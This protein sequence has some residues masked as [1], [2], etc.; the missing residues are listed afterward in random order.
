MIAR[1]H[2]PFFRIAPAIEIP[3][4]GN[5]PGIRYRERWSNISHPD[6]IDWS[7]YDYDISASEARSRFN[8]L[9][10]RGE[11][12]YTLKFCNGAHDLS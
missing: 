2:A 11:E 4:D 6:V 12:F 9:I 3:I 8:K 1:A 5:R 7:F 10:R